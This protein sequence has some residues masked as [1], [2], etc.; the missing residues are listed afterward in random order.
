MIQQNLPILE[1]E[2]LFM[3]ILNLRQISL[4]FLK[5]EL[6]SVNHEKV[7]EMLNEIFSELT[8]EQLSKLAPALAKI[9][10]S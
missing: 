6:L 7:S 3:G 5:K 8:P 9:A 4:Y 1:D 10:I 2:L